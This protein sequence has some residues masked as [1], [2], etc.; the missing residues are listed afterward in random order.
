MSVA[1]TENFLLGLAVGP[2]SFLTRWENFAL[3]VTI[4]PHSQHV[5]SERRKSVRRT[6]TRK[7][8]LNGIEVGNRFEKQM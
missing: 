6:N 1:E 2:E 8:A 3:S 4:F 5:A 7:D